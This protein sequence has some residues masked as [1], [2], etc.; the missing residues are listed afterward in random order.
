MSINYLDNII[1]RRTTMKNI[2]R[3]T[4]L[5]VRIMSVLWESESNL[6][7]QEI[8]GRLQEDKLSVQSITQAMKRLVSKKVV[9]VSEHVLVSNVY[10]R[11]FEPYYSQDEYLASE[12][13]RLK[14]SIFLK[15]RANAV[16][17]MATLINNSDDQEISLEQIDELQ[18][19]IEQ[20]KA[21]LEKREK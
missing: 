1:K 13:E 14:S 11:T 19:I 6:T 16:S 18:K 12:I 21:C 15:K 8:A 5:E 3:L 4:D 7:I 20:K 9:V 10:A 2:P 17:V